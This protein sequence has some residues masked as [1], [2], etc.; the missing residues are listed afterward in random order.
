M[1]K[2]SAKIATLGLGVVVATAMIGGQAAAE[3][4]TAAADQYGAR[5]HAEAMT[6]TVAGTQLTGSAANAALDHAPQSSATVTEL[7]LPGVAEAS[8]EALANLDNPAGQVVTPESC[9]L[10]ELEAI[11]GI[12]RVDIVCPEATARLDGVL[13]YARGLG[14]EVVL[15]PSVSGLLDTLG[16]TE[17]VT[18]ATDQVFADVIGPV[19]EA[20]TGTPLEQIVDPATSTV[21]DVI[22]DALTLDSTARIVIAPALA[23][24]ASAAD[25][26]TARAHSQGI[27]IELLPVN[28]VGATN[29]LLP[30]DLDVGEPLITLT[31][32]EAMAKSSYNRVTGQRGTPEFGASAVTIAFGSNALTEALGVPQTITI[33][34]ATEQCLLTGT[35]L[36]ICVSVASAGTDADGNPYATSTAI[37]LF[38]GLEGGGITLS[39]GGVTSSLSGQAAQVEAPAPAPEGALPRTG[40]PAALPVIGAG[41]LSAAVLIRR[42]LLGR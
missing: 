21:E 20:L 29:G 9:L 26:V 15:E 13:P 31:I 18:G 8:I 22:G 10:D 4:A 35:P 12:R 25:I 36:E 14:A 33:P 42:T 1:R 19:V 27:R 2:T 17:T 30:E 34:V 23:E 24:V 6:I 39:T 3:T 16:L 32:G 41:L 40:G 7:L 38:K 37:E 5:A 28:E 11:P